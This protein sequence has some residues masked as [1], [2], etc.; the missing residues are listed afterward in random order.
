MTAGE[1]LG[2]AKIEDVEILFGQLT[3]SD[4]QRF[5]ENHIGYARPEYFENDED[6]ETIDDLDTWDAV[7]HFG[8]DELLEEIGEDYIREWLKEEEE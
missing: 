5:V 7:Q 2:L 1:K 8:K 3:E 6:V 4:K